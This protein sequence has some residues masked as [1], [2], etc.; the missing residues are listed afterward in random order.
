MLFEG[1]RK[2]FF[3]L[4]CIG[5]RFGEL[6]QTTKQKERKRGCKEEFLVI[7][8]ATLWCTTSI[9][10][11]LEWKLLFASKRRLRDFEK[12]NSYKLKPP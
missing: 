10:Y 5:E 12:L 2:K 8:Q 9:I 7:R 1:M 3:L 11:S 6:E 4:L